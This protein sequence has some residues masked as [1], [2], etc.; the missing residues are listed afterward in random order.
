MNDGG[1]EGVRALTLFEEVQR[2]LKVFADFLIGFA[3]EKIRAS[4]DQR[5][6]KPDAI[7]SCSASGGGDLF[8]CLQAVFLCRCDQVVIERAAVCVNIGIAGVLYLGALVV[9]FDLR[10]CRAFVFCKAQDAI[11]G[12]KNASVTDPEAKRERVRHI[13]ALQGMKSQGNN[14]GRDQME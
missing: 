7:L 12:M 3:F 9:C 13:T 14:V 10:D 1:N 2:V 5:F 6:D 8:I 11:E 4:G